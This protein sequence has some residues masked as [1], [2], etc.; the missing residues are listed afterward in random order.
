MGMM[1]FALQETED[2]GIHLNSHI[3]KVKQHRLENPGQKE[4]SL[5][6]M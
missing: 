6:Q 4:T 5:N 2:Y 1:T 3:F